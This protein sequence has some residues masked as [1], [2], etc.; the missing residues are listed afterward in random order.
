M[1]RLGISTTVDGAVD[2]GHFRMYE[3]GLSPSATPERLASRVK[4]PCGL[5]TTVSLFP[6]KGA[7]L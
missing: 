7:L 1:V 4:Q 6:R 2:N 3:K 5:W